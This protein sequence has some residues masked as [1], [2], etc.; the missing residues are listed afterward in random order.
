MSHIQYAYGFLRQRRIAQIQ[1]LTTKN[2]VVAQKPVS[3]RWRL[4]VRDWL[5]RWQLSTKSLTKLEN[6]ILNTQI[7]LKI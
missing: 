3:S 6:I 1:K 7:K 4:F 5:L 2:A